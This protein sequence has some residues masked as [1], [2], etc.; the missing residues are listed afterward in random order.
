MDSQ[1]AT[2]RAKALRDEINRQRYLV[3]VLN[4]E[5]MSEAALDSLKHE[6]TLLEATYP[7]L[8][9]PDSP[10]QRVAGEPL[11]GFQKVEHQTRMLSLNDVFSREELLAWG[12]RIT[13]LLG[14]SPSSYHAELKLDGF[15]IA[16]TYHDGL[17]VQAATRGDGYIGEDVTLNV[18]TIQ[19]IPLRLEVMEDT[20]PAL[21]AL[22]QRA[23]QGRFEVR[24]EAYISKADFADLNIGQAER[25]LPLFANPRNTAAGSMRQLDPALA[26]AR[27]LRFFAYA[28][29]TDFGL[30]T[31]ADEH[32][33]AQ[34]LGIPVEPNSR[35]C[36]SLDE[37]WQ[38]LQ[39]WEERRKK[40]G[41]GTDG[42]VVVVNNCEEF[43]RLGV[44]GKAPRGSVAYKFA[45]EQATTRVLDI[46]LRVG[47]TGALTPTAVLEPV[48]IAGSTVA[49]AT[50]HNADE[51][52]R[53]D[54]RIGDTV[55][56]QKAGDII[57]E[58]LQ[59]VVGLRPEGSQPYRFPEE[60]NGVPV[61]RREGEVAHYVDVSAIE[62]R[63]GEE[64][65]ADTSGGHVV[66]TDILK[67]RLEHFASR[68]AMDIEGLGEKICAKLIDAGLVADFADLFRLTVPQVL[69]VE[70][71]AEVSAKALL[72]AIESSK[73]QPFQ[74]LL[75]GLG[76]RHVG[77]E[78]ARTIVAYLQEQGLHDL[79]LVLAHLRALT[80]EQFSEL[81][82]IGPVV[83]ESLHRY[84][85]SAPEQA[86]F[87]ELLHLGLRCVVPRAAAIRNG[88]LTGKTLVVTGTLSRFSR[89]EAEERI[90]Q[91]G[92]KAG[93]SV[94]G[95]TSYL[96]AGEK[97]GSKLTKAEAMGVPVL[98]EEEFLHLLDGE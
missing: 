70:G 83:G 45:A 59:V 69:G 8:V 57:P 91:A 20:P 79:P 16:L 94:S 10:T 43:R 95:E 19:A 30:Q 11:P 22:A 35:V 41:Y 86:V 88:R 24:G 73:D 55:V 13:K 61:V 63:V 93:A 15:A 33:V 74:R 31:H 17:L 28:L 38:F 25:G 51:I 49:R 82:D 5:E 18:R 23:L 37:V 44:V 47:R 80:V 75:F 58:V 39:H 40:L 53:K 52:A 66:L 27:R 77:A 85:Q 6:L 68:G 12:E 64:G 29:A 67:R 56:L 92:G 84:F 1:Q 14:A 96:V 34:A 97:A 26:A 60:I 72:A 9:T 78:T 4:H 3:H 65:A 48:L 42:A 50:L 81:P 36:N 87:D 54:V 32:A 7:E 76:I 46:E 21:R 2:T 90:R 62:A 71:F 98:T 89:E